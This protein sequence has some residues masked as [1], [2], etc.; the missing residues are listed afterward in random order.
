MEFKTE[1]TPHTFNWIFPS[2]FGLRARRA[3]FSVCLC[4]HLFW[5]PQSASIIDFSIPSRLSLSISPLRR[6]Q[7]KPINYFPRNLFPPIDHDLLGNGGERRAKRILRFLT[8]GERLSR[9][10]KIM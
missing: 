10:Y 6:F 8:P 7:R 5:H 2:H 9:R 1:H 4:E 3:Q